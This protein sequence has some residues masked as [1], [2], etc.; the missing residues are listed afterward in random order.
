MTDDADTGENR[1]RRKERKAIFRMPERMDPSLAK[2]VLKIQ[3]ATE[4]SQADTAK[5]TV[6][7]RRR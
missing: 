7:Q 5:D 4:D 1:R 3:D 6:P 2:L